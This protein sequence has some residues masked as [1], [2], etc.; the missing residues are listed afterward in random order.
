MKD[1]LHTSVSDCAEANTIEYSED[2]LYQGDRIS[3]T[4]TCLVCGRE[5]ERIYHHDYDLHLGDKPEVV[6]LKGPY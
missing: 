5:F 4:G 3:Y 6:H 2:M 1:N